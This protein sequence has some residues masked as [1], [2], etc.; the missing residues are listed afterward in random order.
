MTRYAVALKDTDNYRLLCHIDTE[1]EVDQIRS[2]QQEEAEPE[3][4]SISV[5]RFQNL[6]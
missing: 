4:H 3:Q 6:T 1:L 5:K 2:R